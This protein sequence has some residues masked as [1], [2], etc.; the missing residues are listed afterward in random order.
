MQEKEEKKELSLACFFST[1]KTSSFVCILFA[2]KKMEID[3]DQNLLC[4]IDPSLIH[5]ALFFPSL[6]SFVL[7][8]NFP[9]LKK[10]RE[11]VKNG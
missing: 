4:F 2:C 6:F 7:F 1:R 8:P 5:F 11:R 3:R 10:S 9:R